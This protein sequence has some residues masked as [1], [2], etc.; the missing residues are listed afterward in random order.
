MPTPRLSASKE[1]AI[2]CRAA[3]FKMEKEDIET[4][5]WT[6]AGVVMLNQRLLPENVDPV[7]CSSYQAVAEAISSM[8]V[9]GAPAIGI[10]GAMGV[11]LGVRD[12]ADF[13]TVCET[14]EAAR[15]TAV[16]LPWAINRMRQ[17]Y[18]DLC[19][20]GRDAEYLAGKMI[21]EAEQI[22]SEDLAACKQIGA[23][24]APLVPDNQIV[25]TYCNAGALAT[26]GYGTAIG[27][28]RSAVFDARKQIEVFVCE[29]RP[30]LQGMRLTAWELH[31]LGIK[32]T[33]ITD[34]MAGHF[35]SKGNIGCVVVGA[36]RIAA[37]GDVANKIGTYSVAVLARANGVPFY[38][39]APT[40]TIDVKCRSGRD[41]PIE[42]RPSEE[43][44]SF[45]GMKVAPE[46]VLAEN[47]AF[48]VTPAR[49]ISAIITERGVT[50]PSYNFS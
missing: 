49:Y 5:Y 9:R 16:N 10:A 3:A 6:D 14:L 45:R 20:E 42:E 17:R 32:T 43:V 4:I 22:K 29:T 31:R 24:G 28:I 7:T 33:V 18:G 41:I 25:L 1:R 44:T 27:V 46:G 12:G 21:E 34:C 40:S 50:Y 8:V 38:V 37:N 48:D 30:V 11:A 15:P 39:A 13:E 23:N 26:A 2:S 47:P 19:A 35:L 36:D